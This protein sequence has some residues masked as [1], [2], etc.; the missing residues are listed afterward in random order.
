MDYLDSADTQQIDVVPGL[1]QHPVDRYHSV[2]WK[3][4]DELSH[5]L[6]PP[7]ITNY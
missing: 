4:I 3:A 5:G 6:A 7:R 1:E 2:S